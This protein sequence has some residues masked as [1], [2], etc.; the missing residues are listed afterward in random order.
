MLRMTWY[1]VAPPVGVVT[2]DLPVGPLVLRTL[3][4]KTAPA[5]PQDYLRKSSVLPVRNRVLSATCRLN[6]WPSN[7][8]AEPQGRFTT[9]QCALPSPFQVADCPARTL[10]SRSL[11]SWVLKAVC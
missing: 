9:D 4:R 7:Q 11:R 10:L 1:D 3:P 8:C 5:N 2:K 6:K